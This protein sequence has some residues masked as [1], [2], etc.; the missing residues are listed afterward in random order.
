MSW[1]V[2]AGRDRHRTP[3]SLAKSRALE[4]DTIRRRV[5]RIV[6]AALTIVCAQAAESAE[7]ILF[8]GNSF[9]YGGNS[10]VQT[11]RPGTVTDLNATGQGGVPAVF[12]AFTEESGLPFD[13]SVEAVGGA[14][15]DFH[16]RHKVALLSRSWD[17]VVLQSH[18]TL[19]EKA[20]GDASTLIEYSARLAALFHERN[21]NVDVR[22]MAT[23]SRADQTYLPTGHWFGKSIDVM[24][25]DVRA[26]SDR[27]VSAS[28]FVRAVIPVGQAWTRAIAMAVAAANPYQGIPTGQVSLWASDNYHGSVYG[29]YLEALVIFGCITGRD[30]RTLGGNE[31][32]AAELGIPS[33]EVTALQQV[34]FETLAAESGAPQ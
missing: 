7:S 4:I 9:T 28:P 31:T 19:D 15:L 18:S 20:P 33:V 13:V 23:W 17:H 34:A 24:A 30:P 25:R 11:F 8:V 2:W 1:Q 27:A 5:L 21:P 10:P 6:A 29:Y 32:A 26:A 3:R 22:L 16:Y 12:K 14:N